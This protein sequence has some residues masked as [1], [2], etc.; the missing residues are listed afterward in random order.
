MGENYLMKTDKANMANSVEVRLPLLDR[1]LA[2]YAFD[3]PAALKL[4]GGTEKYILRQ[5]LRDL[6]PPLI[7]ERK[8]MGFSTPVSDWMRGEIGEAAVALVAGSELIRSHTDPANLRKWIAQAEAR[9]LKRP[10]AFWNL[11]ALAKWHR[12]F[13]P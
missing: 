10:R 12:T 9:K 4:R 6:L 1:Y 2:Q 11:Y 3:L 5:A 7:L 13:F 8:K